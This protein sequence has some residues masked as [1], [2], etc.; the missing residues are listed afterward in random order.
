MPA[1]AICR[2]FKVQVIANFE[3]ELPEK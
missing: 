2:A 3:P 1:K